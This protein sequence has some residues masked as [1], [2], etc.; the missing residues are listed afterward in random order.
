MLKYETVLFDLDGTLIDTNELIITTFLHVLGIHLPGQYTRDDIIS[1]MGQTL[2][3]QMGRY[4]GEE[5][6]DTLIEA[7][8]DYNLK[9]HDEYVKEFERVNDTLEQLQSLGVTMGIVTTKQRKTAEMGAKLF[10]IDQYMNAFVAFESTKKHKPNP[11]PVLKGIELTAADPQTTIMIGDSQYDIQAAQE[12]GIDSAGVAW[13]MKGPDF[14]KQF[15]PTYILNDMA[16]LIP[17]IK[18]E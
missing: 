5:L 12:A 13:S 18:G 2:A 6:R 9:I 10:G 15:N 11:D 7:Y 3:E 4:G 17:I 1:H 8:R 14:L 16:D